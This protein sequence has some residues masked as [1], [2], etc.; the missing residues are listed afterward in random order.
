MGLFSS[1][2]LLAQEEEIRNLPSFSK[3][4]VSPLIDLVLIKGDKESIRIVADNV[5]LEKINTKN[6][7]KTLKVFLDNARMGTNNQKLVDPENPNVIFSRSKYAGSK[8]K[9]YLTYKS[10][11]RLEVR[12]D[13]SVLCQDKLGS[14]KLKIKLMGE[15]E[16]TF[17]SIDVNRFVLSS[18]G[19][20]DIYIGGGAADLQ[21]YRVFG[22]GQI[23]TTNV[24]S[25]LAKVS[26]F[27]AG[28]IRISTDNALK[29][30]TFGESKIYYSGNPKVTKSLILGDV[31]IRSI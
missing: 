11:E 13:G 19:E 29:L 2:K 8:V 1:G 25:E 5:S 4:I 3:I 24:N 21:I 26:V 10:L 12:G 30:K 23:N 28:E 27:G 20:N 18:F 17:A 14:K 9:V 31:T 16:A 6:S 15:I 7:G 22:E